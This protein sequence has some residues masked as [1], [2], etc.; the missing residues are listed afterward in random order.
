MTRATIRFRFT[1]NRAGATGGSSAQI[2]RAVNGVIE[3]IALKYAEGTFR[4]V[5]AD[6]QSR[7]MRDIDTEISWMAGRMRTALIGIS[8]SKTGPN[9][10]TTMAHEVAASS[11]AAGIKGAHSASDGIRW[12][13]RS[14]QYLEWKRSHYGHTRW[15]L[16]KGSVLGGSLGKK[17]TWVS[18]Y[19]PVQVRVTR[20]AGLGSSV[21]GSGRALSSRQRYQSRRGYT[22]YKDAEN[23]NFRTS[24]CRIEV[25]ALGKITPQ[26]LPGL[27]SGAMGIYHPDG[28]KSGL[29]GMLPTE[30][31]YRLGG[32]NTS[33]PY[34]HTVEPFL[35]FFL[36]RA[37]PNALF[38]RMEQGLKTR[39][40]VERRTR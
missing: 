26:M 39:L 36:T 7:V 4:T 12:P 2:S 13:R 34:R 9:G 16:N 33:V 3:D 27:A 38:L 29:L 11:R 23:S 20:G 24:V 6:I 10:S 40:D 22:R 17:S 21:I 35:T 25:G 1:F 28:R 15:F 31:A 32:D 8:G 30:I 18:A 5:K 37:V 19:G 14:Q